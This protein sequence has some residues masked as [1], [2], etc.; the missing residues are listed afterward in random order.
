MC[1]FGVY[2]PLSLLPVF[3]FSMGWSL[4]SIHRLGLK[5]NNEKRMTD[6]KGEHRT[7]PQL[8]PSTAVE[9]TVV[10]FSFIGSFSLR[11]ITCQES[12]KRRR[13]EGTSA[14]A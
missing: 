2:W 8:Q 14:T 3:I 9:G 6:P 4:E 1:L 7:E 10:L 11:K 13:R 5:L 12:E